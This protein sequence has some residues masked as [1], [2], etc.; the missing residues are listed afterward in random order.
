[1]TGD[2]V[3]YSRTEQNQRRRIVAALKASLREANA[4]M[5]PRT[6]LEFQVYR[7]DSFQGVAA[8]PPLALRAAILVRAG[9]RSRLRS[10]RRR[11]AA[12]C[13]IAIGIGAIDSLPRKA[14]SEGD[15]EAFR[16]SGP[17]LDSMKG[18]R[19]LSVHS[20][21]PEIDSELATELALLDIVARRWSPE[22]AE[23]VI[24]HLKGVI[25]ADV[26]KTMGISQ[27]AVV[28]RLKVAGGSA[29]EGLCERFERLVSSRISP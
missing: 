17:V 5:P 11:E 27:P 8:D 6:R 26:A 22:Q 15:G 24:G 2:I 18:D 21:W 10:A 23:A 3:G 20:P 25:Q 19:R 28:S 4:I 1:M 13:R 16:R 29:V 12:D 9:L 7:G 14:V